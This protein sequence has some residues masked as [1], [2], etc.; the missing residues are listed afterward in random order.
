M[1]FVMVVADIKCLCGGIK[2]SPQK[3]LNTVQ[4]A[5]VIMYTYVYKVF[6][7]DQYTFSK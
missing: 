1:Y 7:A 4:N 5:V 2:Q 3:S 6:G